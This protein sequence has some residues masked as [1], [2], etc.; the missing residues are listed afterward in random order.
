MNRASIS[1]LHQLLMLSAGPIE[2]AVTLNFGIALPKTSPFSKTCTVSSDQDP[3]QIPT[4]SRYR[5]PG[6]VLQQRSYKA[7]V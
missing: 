6:R 5:K 3:V 2:A 4:S 7:I 1:S